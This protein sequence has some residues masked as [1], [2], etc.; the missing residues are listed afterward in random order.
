[1]NKQQLA[2]RDTYTP[3][4]TSLVCSNC[5]LSLNM[6]ERV[7]ASVIDLKTLDNNPEENLPHL[8]EG[9]ISKDIRETTRTAI[10]LTGYRTSSLL[11]VV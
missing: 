9:F 7:S 6:Y 5:D 1:M 10:H 11:V 4:D 8:I 2:R 3:T